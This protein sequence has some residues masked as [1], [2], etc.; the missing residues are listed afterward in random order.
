MKRSF[1]TSQCS[2]SVSQ[3]FILA[4]QGSILCNSA[5]SCHPNVPSQ[6]HCD[7]KMLS[8]VSHHFTVTSQCPVSPAQCWTVM[9]RVTVTS[10]CSVATLYCIVTSQGST[11]TLQC[12]ISPSQ[13]SAGALSQ[14]Y[15]EYHTRNYVCW[16]ARCQLKTLWTKGVWRQKNGIWLRMFSN[17]PLP[18]PA[19]Y[20]APLIQFTF[21]RTGL[22]M[23][24]KGMFLPSAE[25][26]SEQ[27]NEDGHFQTLFSKSSSRTCQK[28][29][30]TTL[31][32]S[33]RK[34]SVERILDSS[35]CHCPERNIS[36]KLDWREGLPSLPESGHWSRRS[37]WKRRG[38]VRLGVSWLQHEQDMTLISIRL[39][40]SWILFL[41]HLYK[42]DQGKSLSGLKDA[43][44]STW[45]S[46][47]FLLSLA[48]ENH[49]LYLP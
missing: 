25:L 42:G 29:G 21:L 41:C 20:E 31:V 37:R 40:S 43:S 5:Q 28:D 18:V 44:L 47:R 17:S 34:D 48:V 39:P 6:L 1:G 38:N 9:L 19:L 7:F 13:G 23:V 11:M 4:P 8:I 16:A 46:Q 3:C 27:Q 2:I 26:D 36:V 33:L 22:G 24:R 10:T 30:E 14:H 15:C 12:S 32:A 45:L 35:N 49:N